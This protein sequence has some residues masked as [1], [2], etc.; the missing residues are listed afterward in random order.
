MIRM[1]NIVEACVCGCASHD[2]DWDLWKLY[3]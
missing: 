3:V 1:R 2:T